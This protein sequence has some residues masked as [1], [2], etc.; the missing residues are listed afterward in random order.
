MSGLKINFHESELFLF[1]GAKDKKY[2]Y[3]KIF[4]CPIG[5]LPMKY[6]GLLVDKN[7]K[8]VKSLLNVWLQDFSHYEMLRLEL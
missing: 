1:W 4:T 5:T 7:R 2:E 6:L 8:K 3:A